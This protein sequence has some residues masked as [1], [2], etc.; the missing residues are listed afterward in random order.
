[1]SETVD[2]ETAD[3][4]T[5]WIAPVETRDLPRVAEWLS[6]K[7]NYQWLHFGPGRQT[8]DEVS[9]KFMLQRDLHLLRTFGPGHL[10][11][12]VG[13]VALSDLDRD[14]GTAALWYVLG[15]KRFGGRG[16]TTRAAAR[17]LHGAFEELELE[18]VY[19]WTVET[20]RP[21]RRLLARLGFRRAGRRRRCHR[22]DGVVYDRLLYDL[23]ADEFEGVRTRE[24]GPRS[25]AAPESVP[26]PVETGS[27]R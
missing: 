27:V 14:F 7:A 2:G 22:I 24:A 12:P 13:L 16:H 18:S 26:S 23:L 11:E 15:D 25:A 4:E 6:R 20:N 19:A 9:L 10:D 1:M 3:G 8:L 21:S 17:L 5:V